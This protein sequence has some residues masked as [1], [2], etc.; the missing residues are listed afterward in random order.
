MH[1]RRGG[2]FRD[3]KARKGF[4]LNADIQVERMYPCITVWKSQKRHPW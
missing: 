3:Y 1:G 4:V 2:L